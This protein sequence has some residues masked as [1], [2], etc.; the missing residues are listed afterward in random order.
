MTTAEAPEVPEAAEAA[1]PGQSHD[2]EQARREAVVATAGHIRNVIGV[3]HALDLDETPPAATYS[4]AA[5]GTA[6][7][8][9]TVRI[10]EEEQAHATV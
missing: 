6:V 8:G 5:A 7:A 3:L 2:E 9:E 4:A 1:E 10:E